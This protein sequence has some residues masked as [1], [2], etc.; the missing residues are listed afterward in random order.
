MR[1]RLL[2]S[3]VCIVLL[4]IAVSACGGSSSSDN[5]ISS[6]SPDAIVS[7]V[8]SAVAGLKSVH[9][10]GSIVSTGVPITLDMDLVSG[11]GARGS[12]SEN[13]VGFQIVALGH[14]VYINGSPAFWR[15]LG[16]SAAAQLF[17]G[18]WL[19]APATGQFASLAS[20][21]NL[22][23]LFNKLLAS[24]GTLTKG[25]TSTVNGQKVVALTDTT[26]GGTLY[27]ATT[28]QPYPVELTKGGSQGGHID[29]SGFNQSVSLAAPANAIDISQ[30]HS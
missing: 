2:A 10:T 30:L 15:R 11:M 19:K 21:T 22:Q 4:A 5:G 23:A 3:I 28:G 25:A 14:E 7:S 29:F 8:N 20:L 6:K 9:I 27:V 1:I 16:G 18:K 26:K 24:H 17:N 12:M 13:G